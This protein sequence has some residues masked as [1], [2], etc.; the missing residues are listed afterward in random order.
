MFKRLG[1]EYTINMENTRTFILF[2]ISGAGKGTQ[3]KLLTE[4]LVKNDSKRE[5][6]YLS[7]GEL[8]RVFMKSGSY[9]AF[10]VKEILDEGGLLPEFLPIWIWTNF[11]NENIKTNTEHLILDGIARRAP[12]APILGR[13]LSFYRRTISDIILINVS[14]ELAIKRLKERGRYDDNDENIAT[15]LDWYKTNV[16]PSINYFRENE[17]FVVHDI[18]GE[19]SVEKVHEDILKSTHLI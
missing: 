15:R 8:F 5:T 19:R 17:G 1:C 7:T 9:T 2:G 14:R 10:K 11:F 13:A 12:E 16:V 6:V 18:D 3:A 4:Y